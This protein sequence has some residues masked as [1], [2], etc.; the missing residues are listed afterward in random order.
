MNRTVLTGILCLFAGSI[1]A[2]TA[3]QR[4]ATC[5]STGIYEVKA[6]IRVV[7]VIIDRSPRTWS[8]RAITVY[9]GASLENVR[10]NYAYGDTYI[11]VRTAGTVDIRAFT[12]VG[13]PA[14]DRHI[15]AIGI[16]TAV[17]LNNC[18]V[19]NA[20]KVYRQN[21]GTTYPTT[22][23]ISA[24]DI[25]NMSDEV[26]R[27]DSPVATAVLSNSRLGNVKTICRG[28]APGRCIVQPTPVP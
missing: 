10:I 19:T 6:T 8:A 13:S 11:S 27:T 5:V 12:A 9:A 7:G 20:R 28:Y 26:F 4:G 16:K 17:Y 3:P 1:G 14:L 2:Q 22:A 21:G 18:I 23:S 25:F 24:C 15:N